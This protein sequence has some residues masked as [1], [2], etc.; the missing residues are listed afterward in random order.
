MKTFKQLYKIRT[1]VI[2]LLMVTLAACESMIEVEPRTTVDAN[3]VLSTPDAIQAAINSVYARLRS[4]RNYGRDLLAVA[5]ALSD[6]AVTTNNS[7]RLI[8]ENRNTSL[9]HLTHWQN[10]YAAIN[11]VNITLEAIANLNF[12][13]APTQATLDSWNGQ[14][15]FLR[16]LYYHDLLRGYAYDP[17]TEVPTQDKGGVPL[18][19]TPITTAQAASAATLPRNSVAEV[20]AQIYTDLND[21][22]TL[23]PAN[24]NGNVSYIATRAAA[25]ALFARVALYNKDYTTAINNATS[26]I[27]LVGSTLSG[28]AYVNAWRSASNN[29]SIF[30]VKFQDANENIGVNTSL[31][32]SF[33][34]SQTLTTLAT[35]GGFGDL[36]P[37]A[38]LRGLIGITGPT[39]GSGTVGQ[40]CT[41]TDVRAQLYVIGP[42]RGSGPK[43]ECIKFIGKNGIVNLDN[44]PVLRKAEN[45]LNRAEAYASSG[46]DA[47]ALTDL[48]AIRTARGLATVNLTGAAL[49]T[50]ILNQRRV[51]FA[52]EGHRW[53]DLKRRGTDILKAP[54]NILSAD[55]RRLANIPQREIDANPNLAQNFGY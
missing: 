13:P 25:H 53:F 45:L 30:E 5:E 38:T 27:A 47:L 3:G 39:P 19:L 42:G 22:A 12:T 40:I 16:A 35:Q 48:N 37:T 43:V 33:T 36:V 50:E 41:G 23:L 2:A 20:Y 31:Q 15:K 26:S 34:T 8:N 14:L 52:F 32:T 46:S 54:E 6:N 7:G 18:I 9:A 44:V 10:S 49:L 21:A 11:E 24:A 28:T 29:E 1:I 55:F 4:E 17:G 51:E